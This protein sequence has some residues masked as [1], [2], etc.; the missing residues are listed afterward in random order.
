MTEDISNAVERGLGFLASQQRDDGGMNPPDKGVLAC[1]KAVLAVALNGRL[2]AAKHLAAW[3]VKHLATGDGQLRGAESLGMFHDRFHTYTQTWIAQGLVRA[4]AYGEAQKLAAWL[5]SQ[6]DEEIGGFRS[7][8]P[9]EGT[10]QFDTL[11]TGMAGLACLAAGRLDEARLAGDFLVRFVDQQPADGKTFHSSADATGRPLTVFPDETKALYLV[12]TSQPGQLY[13]FYGTPAVF[14]AQLHELTGEP[15][16]L[17]TAIQ[18][19]DLWQSCGA[20][21]YQSMASG[22]SGCAA[23]HLYR[24]T[25]DARFRTMALGVAEYLLSIQGDD[26]AWPAGKVDP[27]SSISAEMIVWLTEILA[28]V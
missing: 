23:A 1:Y 3:I 5:V 4:G 14:L 13:F 24:I 28:C 16:H 22:K 18:L 27:A 21:A 6:Q 12:D 25:G 15:R 19:I 10:I 8:G 17:E 2:R 26:G 11:C 20:P 9:K 7:L